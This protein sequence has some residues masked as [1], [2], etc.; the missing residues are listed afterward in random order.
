MGATEKTERVLMAN[1][2]ISEEHTASVFEV[3]ELTSFYC[4]L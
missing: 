3:E 1:T 2:D 4:L